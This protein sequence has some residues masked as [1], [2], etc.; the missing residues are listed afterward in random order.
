MYV[1]IC[2]KLRNDVMLVGGG[3]LDIA[4]V[5]FGSCLIP[6]FEYI[7]PKKGISLAEIMHFSLLKTRQYSRAHWNKARR[8]L[9]CVVI[10]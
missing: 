10:S 4:A 9:L 6:D 2:R 7:R 5:L 3:I 1:A 8:C